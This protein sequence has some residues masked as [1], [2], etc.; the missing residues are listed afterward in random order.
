MLPVHIT[1]KVPAHATQPE[2]RNEEIEW[3]LFAVIS[4]RKFLKVHKLLY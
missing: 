1:L 3:T 4:M 2:K